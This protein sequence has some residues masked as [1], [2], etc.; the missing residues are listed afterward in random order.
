MGDL[1][2]ADAKP[3]GAQSAVGRGVAV[4][5]HH[6]HA[7][8][9]QALFGTDHVHDALTS[10]VEANQGNAVALGVGVECLDHAHDRRIQSDGAVANRGHVVIGH[11][12]RQRGLCHRQPALRQ[13]AERVKRAFVHV[14]SVNP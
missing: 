8:V 5:A 14:M 2:G 4:A 13:L 3:H 7:R 1:R 10:I 6:H 9:G 11:A 12:N